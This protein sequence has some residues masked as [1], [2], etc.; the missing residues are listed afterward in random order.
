MGDHVH[1]SK[2]AKQATVQP[3]SPSF[4]PDRSH[5]LCSSSTGFQHGLQHPKVP[6][7][8]PGNPLA[9][10]R[11]LSNH[12]LGTTRRAPLR[13][14]ADTAASSVASS[15][16]VALGSVQHCGGVGRMLQVWGFP[17]GSAAH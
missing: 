9:A 10:W 7:P 5:K 4:L 13:G 2:M 12:G 16:Y 1:Q 11:H 14:V 8:D 17:K 3:Q 15:N 6:L